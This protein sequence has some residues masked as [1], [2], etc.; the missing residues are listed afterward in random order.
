[1]ALESV[2]KLEGVAE[3][4]KTLG[5][6]G[7]AVSGRV[8][9]ATVKE[10]MFIVYQKALGRIPI[11]GG[12]RPSRSGVKYVTATFDTAGKPRM[13]HRLSYPKGKE[14][15]SGWAQQNLRLKTWVS[16]D[17][18]VATA[19]IGVGPEA[20]YVLQF[21][22]LGTSRYPAAPW[23]TPVFESSTSGMVAEVG[24]QMRTRIERI[25]KARAKAGYVPGSI[26]PSGLRTTGS[27]RDD[28]I[29]ATGKA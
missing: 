6:L 5:M 18:T 27:S 10:A 25:A 1:M 22:E 26:R 9:R 23:L 20:F 12:V 8:L 4:S 3:L 24:G 21:I 2:G 7:A 13:S 29:R 14:V 19:M 16:R 15:D 11:S 17:K 28:R